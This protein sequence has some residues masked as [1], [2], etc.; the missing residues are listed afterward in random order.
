M[1][2]LIF[3]QVPDEPSLLFT[4]PLDPEKLAKAGIVAPPDP[5]IENGSTEPPYRCRGRIGRGGRIIFD[6]WDPLLRRPL[7]PNISSHAPPLHGDG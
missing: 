7:G 4:K 6:R 1:L 2:C 3:V 5:P